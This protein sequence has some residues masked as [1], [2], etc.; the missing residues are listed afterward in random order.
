MLALRLLAF[1]LIA[2]HGADST[3]PN[4]LTQASRHALCGYGGAWLDTR[5]I[6]QET[7]LRVRQA[8][9]RVAAN[10]ALLGEAGDQI[11]ARP[12]DAGVKERDWKGIAASAKAAAQA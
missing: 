12:R 1:A 7:T 10:S 11:A 8:L 3:T 9:T 2:T 5:N 4:G 6:A